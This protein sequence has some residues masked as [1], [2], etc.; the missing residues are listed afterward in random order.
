MQQRPRDAHGGFSLA[1]AV[2][3]GDEPIVRSL[4]GRR[5]LRLRH[6]FGQDTVSGDV[7]QDY[8]S[9]GQGRNSL[10][11][12]SARVDTNDHGAGFIAVDIFI[13]AKGI[14][15]AI[16]ATIA[17]FAPLQKTNR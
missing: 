11:F 14:T 16:C 15:V 5:T 13:F 1:L 4:A 6:I 8:C 2:N 7:D 12:G 17:R 10:I 3:S 9:I